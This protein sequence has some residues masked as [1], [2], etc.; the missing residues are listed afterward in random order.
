[1]QEQARWINEMREGIV[2]K[3]KADAGSAKKCGSG[4][5]KGR[6]DGSRL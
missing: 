2:A 3:L 1:M 5:P 4:T 6:E